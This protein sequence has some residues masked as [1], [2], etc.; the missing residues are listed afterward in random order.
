MTPPAASATAASGR[1]VLLL[2]V[3]DRSEAVVRRYRLAR[4]S[5]EP[6]G[7]RQG[8]ERFAHLRRGHD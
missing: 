3:S 6:R 5:L 1:R 7:P 4:L 8:D 2:P